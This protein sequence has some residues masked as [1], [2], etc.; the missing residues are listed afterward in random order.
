MDWSQTRATEIFFALF[1]TLK[2]NKYTARSELWEKI[3]G[4]FSGFSHFIFLFISR[5][6]V[7][8]YP[9]SFQYFM[10]FQWCPLY[11][12]KFQSST[13]NRKWTVEIFRMSTYSLRGWFILWPS[14]WV[15]ALCKMIKFLS[16]FFFFFWFILFIQ[17]IAIIEN[18]WLWTIG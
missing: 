17:N 12:L 13:C 3:P 1:E 6:R 9:N 2:P 16:S 4:N 14:Q 10:N 8:K 7:G 18:E 11:F 15:I 5:D